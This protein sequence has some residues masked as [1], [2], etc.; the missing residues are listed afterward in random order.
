MGRRLVLLAAG[1]WV[2]VATLE[3]LVGILFD[4]LGVPVVG[5][6]WAVWL[7]YFLPTA[8]AARLIAGSQGLSGRRLAVATGSAVF[9]A[10]LVWYPITVA[11]LALPAMPW[12]E[13]LGVAANL[14]VNLVFAIV[15]VAVVWVVSGIFART[16]TPN[17][18]A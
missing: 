4:A 16:G 13:G 10:V 8:F 12:T 7:A 11:L 9:A 14:I 1:L 3:W 15:A 6:P 18:L 5:F 2:V 17:K